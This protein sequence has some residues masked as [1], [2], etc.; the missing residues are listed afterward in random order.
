MTQFKGAVSQPV[1]CV[2]QFAGA[3]PQFAGGMPQ[4]Q[5]AVCQFPERGTEIGSVVMQLTSPVPAWEVFV[6]QGAGAECL[7]RT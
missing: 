6:M 4:F 2:T 3:V 5:G 7:F 1:D